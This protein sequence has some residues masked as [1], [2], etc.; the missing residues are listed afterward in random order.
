MFPEVAVSLHIALPFLSPSANLFADFKEKFACMSMSLDGERFEVS[1]EAYLESE[2]IEFN[3]Y[4]IKHQNPL[5]RKF[6][7]K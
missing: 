6:G 7:P 2:Y 1:C 3:I 5:M 4:I